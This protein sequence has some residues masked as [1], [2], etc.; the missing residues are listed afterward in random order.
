MIL[1]VGR[2]VAGMWRTVDLLISWS[3][4]C[5]NLLLMKVSVYVSVRIKNDNF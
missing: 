1:F 4:V 5:Y 3:T 2:D